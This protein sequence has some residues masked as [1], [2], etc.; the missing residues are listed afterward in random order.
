MPAGEGQIYSMARKDGQYVGA[1]SEMADQPPH[2]NSYVT[3]ADADAAAAKAKEAGGNVV[4]EPF[5]VLEAGRMAVVQ[6]PTG[7]FFMVWQPRESIGA[8]LVNAHGALCWNEL[9]T[10]DTG[11]AEQFYA[12]LFGWTYERTTAG[13]MPYTMVSNGE[14]RNGGIR[15]LAPPEQ[16]MGIP[17]NW[18]VYFGAD[19]V[20]DAVS[21]TEANGGGVLAPGMDLEMGRIAVLRDPAGA[22]FA[23]FEGEMDP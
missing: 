2:W 8:G 18:L 22:V 21:Y 20:D 6:D 11:R 4:M 3:V 7:A 19:S 13:P 15:A 17:P 10:T 16:E 14:T 5:E 12:D 1:L 9:A 23:V